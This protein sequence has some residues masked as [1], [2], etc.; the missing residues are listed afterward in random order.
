MD[1]DI[2]NKTGEE[3]LGC[4]EVVWRLWR[5]CSMGSVHLFVPRKA[6]AWRKRSGIGIEVSL[7]SSGIV[8][9]G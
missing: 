2:K 8:K 4:L 6:G 7:L 3:L 5:D 1:L 9:E